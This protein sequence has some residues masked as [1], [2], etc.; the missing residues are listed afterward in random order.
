MRSRKPPQEPADPADNVRPIL[1]WAGGKRQL[2]PALR[3]YYPE[4]FA[5]Y[6]EPFLGSGAVFLDC[7][8]RGLLDGRKVQ[9]S[10]INADVIGCYRMVRDDV[11]SVIEALERLDEGHQSRGRDHFYEV[12]DDQ[13]NTLRREVHASDDAAGG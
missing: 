3:R 4:S 2:L 9:L 1:K 10:D 6:I 5:R 11:D 13:F 8:N 7:H 12:R